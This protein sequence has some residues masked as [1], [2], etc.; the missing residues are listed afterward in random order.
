MVQ[1]NQRVNKGDVLYQ[2]DK[3][4]FEAV[5]DKLQAELELNN[6]IYKQ[7]KAGR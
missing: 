1:A 6:I 3:L 7:Q 5:V 4:P 2:I